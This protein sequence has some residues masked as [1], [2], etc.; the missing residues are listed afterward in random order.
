M[1]RLWER[2]TLLSDALRGRDGL[3]GDA[4]RR[5]AALTPI[6][7]PFRSNDHWLGMEFAAGATI[8]EDRLLFTAHYADDPSRVLPAPRAGCCSTSGPR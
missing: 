3:L 8:A 5:G 7:L 4:G 6:Q 1:P 2:V